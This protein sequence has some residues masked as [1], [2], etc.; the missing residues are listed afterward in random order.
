MAANDHMKSLRINPPAPLRSQKEA[1]LLYYRLIASVYGIHLSDMEL[2]LL[3][4]TAL[5]GTI[6]TPPARSSFIEEHHSSKASLNNLVSRL[7]KRGLLVKDSNLKIRVRP[8]I[9][10]DFQKDQYRFNI[11]V[12]VSS[13][14]T[15]AINS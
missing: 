9:M 3:A 12:S 4:H 8:E 11:N 7:Q 6:S 2:F 1:A 13:A 15:T 5:W 10:V 14:W